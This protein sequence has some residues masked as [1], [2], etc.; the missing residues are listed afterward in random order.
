MEKRDYYEVLGVERNADGAEIK[1]AYRNLAM[2]YHPDRNPGDDEAAE[3]MK[4]VNEAYAVLSDAQKR[5]LYDTYGHAGLEGFTQEDIFGG[6]DF[7][8]IF[9]EFGLGDIF[10]FGGG[11][12]D[13]LFG[14]RRGGARRGPTRGA[15]LRYDLPMTLEEAAASVE[16]TIELPRGAVCLACGGKGATA[17]NLEACEACQGTGQIVKEQRSGY[18]VMRQITVCGKCR[19]RGQTIKEPCAECEGKG[20]VEHVEEMSVKIPPGADTGFRVRIEGAGE[21]EGDLPGDLYV[22]VNVER[23]PVF[24]RHGDDLYL[25]KD[26]EFTTAALGG[27][28]EVPGLDGDLT[29]EIPE[30]TQTG[31]VFRV[32]EKGMPRLNGFGKGDEYVVVRVTTPTDLSRKEKQL[33][34]EFDKL[35]R[36]QP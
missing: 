5:R 8:S 28:I 19:G 2:Q 18:S 26:I 17:D 36:K 21:K 1:R 20:Y 3:R 27:E 25:Q 33:L 35:R 6:V 14:G 12:F 22:I 32:A 23:H 31:S 11:L 13:G 10:G 4:E 9:R 30:G 15:D 29:L 24:E 7:A 34:K 16:K